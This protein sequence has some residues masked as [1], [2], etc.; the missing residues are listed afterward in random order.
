MT[1]ETE[2]GKARRNEMGK[3]QVHWSHQSE[4]QQTQQL[5]SFAF[6]RTRQFVLERDVLSQID[7]ND[8][9]LTPSYLS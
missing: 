5:Y 8:L 6:Y 3:A 1:E 9:V 2:E 4:W 7:E